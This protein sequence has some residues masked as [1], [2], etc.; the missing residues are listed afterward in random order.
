[1]ISDGEITKHGVELF[2]NY[3]IPGARCRWPLL[4]IRNLVR[5]PSAVV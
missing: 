4:Q 2:V 3:R 5:G 1:M